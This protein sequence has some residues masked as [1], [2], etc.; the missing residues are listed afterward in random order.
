MSTLNP[1]FL[2]GPGRSGTTLLYKLLCLHPRVAFISNYDVR[3]VTR[4][5]VRPA[6]LLSPNRP[7]VRRWAWFT[8]EGRANL[9]GR[10]LLRRLIPTPVEGEAVYRG[11]GLSL[12]ESVEAVDSATRARMRDRFAR[13]QHRQGAALLL[14]KRTANNRRIPTL[15]SV[16]PEAR[17]V[18][19][20]RD[21]RAVVP[22]LTKA[23]W[24]LD[25]HV[26]WAGG[27]TPREMNLDRNGMLELAANNWLQEANAL[28]RG[29]AG[30]DAARLLIVRYEDL[31]VAPDKVIVIVARFIGLDPDDSYLAEVG[32]AHVRPRGGKRESP[33][34]A[35]EM[36]RVEQTMAPALR[37]L[38]YLE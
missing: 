7:A 10:T 6:M 33:L 5:L 12:A 30:I 34:T 23:E 22:S 31:M 18:L 20:W 36:E 35:A 8:S 9:E 17:Y 13:I 14:L 24:W 26:W 11:C 37:R 15:E 27:R 1:V 3:A 38:R 28:D 29:I 19:I 32:K 4:L 21:G 16:F 2:L 25:H